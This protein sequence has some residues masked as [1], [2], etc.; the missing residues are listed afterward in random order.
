MAAR[1]NRTAERPPSHPGALL[2][3]IVIPNSGMPVSRAAERLGVTRQ[4]L[5]R[6]LAEKL[7]V[8]PAMALRLARLFGSSPDFW[9]RMQQTHDLWYASRALAKDIQAIEPLERVA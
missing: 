7:G 5:H 8:S 6:L 2:R 3:E 4:T 9:L 1:S